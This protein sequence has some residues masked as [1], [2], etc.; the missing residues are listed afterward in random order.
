VPNL[1]KA[2]AQACLLSLLLSCLPASAA[3]S[4]APSSQQGGASKYSRRFTVMVA[5]KKKP[6]L[7]DYERSARKRDHDHNRV[8]TP[9]ELEVDEEDLPGHLKVDLDDYTLGLAHQFSGTP[10]SYLWGYP[11][12]ETI[13]AMVSR[14]QGAH[15]DRAS[16]LT[17]GSSREGRD[18]TALR[19]ALPDGRVRPK[20]VVVGQQHA[21]EWMAHQ[22]VLAT[23]RALLEDPA[24]ADLLQAY[25]FWLVPLANPDGYQYCRD[26]D[27]SWRKNRLRLPDGKYG[28]VDL[29][30]NFPANFRRKADRPDQVD[31]DWGA[32]D[33]PWSPQYRG[34]QAASE[35][36]TLALMSLLD[37]PGVQGVVD[38]HGFGCKVVLPDQ[39]GKVA[40]GRYDLAGKVFL[41]DLGPDYQVLQFHQLYPI[42]GSLAAYAD[43]HG[44]VGIT[45]EVGKSFQP[46]PS[47]IPTVSNAAARA[48][49]DFSRALSRA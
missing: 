47:K 39:P 17:L 3:P 2:A 24:N 22:V 8:I 37:E 48:I 18:I 32:S 35:P 30:R 11:D 16:L 29:N 20:M 6:V 13:G 40:R 43:Q 10:S 46:N 19:I 36:E 5:G 4:E 45:L 12:A 14:L 42:S 27:L 9:D 25:E 15:P 44:A 49:L 26:V 38:V 34:P 1:L 23:A 41:K 33:R 21:R 31:D 7:L 28:G